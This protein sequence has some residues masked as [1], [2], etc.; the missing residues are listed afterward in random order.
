MYILWGVSVNCFNIALIVGVKIGAAETLAS[1]SSG[2]RKDFKQP[3]YHK[4]IVSFSLIPDTSSQ[5]VYYPITVQTTCESLLSFLYLQSVSLTQTMAS[6][7]PQTAASEALNNWIIREGIINACIHE[8][9]DPRTARQTLDI[10][11]PAALM[12][13]SASFKDDSLRYI[14]P[15][16]L[17]TKDLIFLAAL[18]HVLPIIRTQQP[19]ANAALQITLNHVSTG[20]DNPSS[21]CAVLRGKDLPV[22]IAMINGHNFGP[23]NN[24]SHLR[25]N[26]YMFTHIVLKFNTSQQFWNT[27]AA[28]ETIFNGVKGIRKIP[29]NANVMVSVQL[30]IAGGLGLEQVL[31]IQTNSNGAAMTPASSEA[32]ATQAKAKGIELISQDNCR[33]AMGQFALAAYLYGRDIKGG[34]TGAHRPSCVFMV[35]LYVLAMQVCEILW[36][37]SAENTSEKN[38]WSDH[39]YRFA[40]AAQDERDSIAAHQASI[41]VLGPLIVKYAMN[42]MVRDVCVGFHFTN[43][44]LREELRRW[45]DWSVFVEALEEAWRI[46]KA[47]L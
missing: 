4:S 44:I 28:K 35:E 9:I 23:S 42:Y 27:K 26:K 14:L 43:T 6:S 3:L 25:A 30:E 38:S 46:R 45:P 33:Q 36:Q 17:V 15:V 1:T 2:Q 8:G 18:A 16:A 20:T 10:K 24:P 7:T 40:R 31:D 13:T 32:L 5:I 47:E 22:L 12:Q 37:K 19:I 34:R 39:S 21:F 11:L 41:T 29:V